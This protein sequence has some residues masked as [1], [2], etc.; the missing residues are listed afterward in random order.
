ML[1][2]VFAILSGLVPAL[3][4]PSADVEYFMRDNGVSCV[5]APCPVYDAVELAGG[6][7]TM[8]TGID[9][10]A[11]ASSDAQRESLGSEIRSSLLVVNGRFERRG[12]AVVFVVSR[13]VR[14]M[15]WEPPPPARR[16]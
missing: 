10:D 9:I 7:V 2:A 12:D 16:P 4:Q 14:R 6:R 13:V 8:V 15:P 5:R 1:A 11:V 3:A